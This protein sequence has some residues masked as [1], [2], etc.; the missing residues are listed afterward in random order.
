MTEA[1]S[2]NSLIGRFAQFVD[3][4][5]GVPVL[6]V[7]LFTLG[8][9][10]A[11]VVVIVLPLC[12]LITIT[13]MERFG[14]ALQQMSVSGLIVALGLLMD[15]AIV[16]AENIAARMSKGDTPMH[17]AIEGVKQLLPGIMSSFAT[18]LLVF[19]SLAF[20]TGEIGQVLRIVPI[21]L[22]LVLLVSLF[23]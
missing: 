9:R 21:V 8:W 18:T 14:I 3:R 5:A 16:I 11:V 1:C 2:A 15:D 7:L 19:G 20:I 6:L 17:A 13:L 23:I 12:G 4:H 10:A 22:I